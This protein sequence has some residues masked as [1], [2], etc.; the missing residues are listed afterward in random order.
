MLLK[1]GEIEQKIGMPAFNET[2]YGRIWS[3]LKINSRINEMEKQKKAMKIAGK[4]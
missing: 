3:Y 1:I 2:R 4:K